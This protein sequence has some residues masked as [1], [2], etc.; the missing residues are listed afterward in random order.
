M[1]ADQIHQA[2]VD[3]PVITVGCS[4]WKLDEGSGM[5]AGDSFGGS[6]NGTLN[7]MD[8]DSWITGL[9]GGGLDFDGIDDYVE[10]VGYTGVT[11]SSP[12]TVAAWIKTNTTGEFVSWGKNLA[13]KKWI[14]RVQDTNGTPG[15]I[16][17]EVNDGYIVGNTDVRDDTW[18][19]VAAVLEEG[20]TD[21]SHVKFYVDGVEETS[22]SA[23]L[24]EPVN[25][26]DAANVKIGAFLDTGGNKYF[27]GGIDDVHIYDYALDESEIASLA[28]LPGDFDDSRSIGLPDL[29]FFVKHWL[30]TECNKPD[31]HLCD[32]DE[33]HDIKIEDFVYFAR[34]WLEPL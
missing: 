21:V 23:V 27:T 17:V 33:D 32:F 15:A 7:N 31:C 5:V 34:Y 19:H 8:A 10:I 14:F 16:R 3:V 11:G 1:T 13:G 24:P 9:S 6:R 25:T 30:V 12:R 26:S 20:D 4:R 2:A 18:H 29:A 28:R 22:Y